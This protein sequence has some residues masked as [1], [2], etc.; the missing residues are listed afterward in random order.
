MFVFSSVDVETTSVCLV[1]NTVSYLTSEDETRTL[2][3]VV[4]YV[5][6]HGSELF[7]VHEIEVNLFICGDVYTD[8]SFDEIEQTFVLKLEIL[9]PIPFLGLFIVN[10]LEK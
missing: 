7:V 8:V 6:K 1:G 10:S 5:F 2:H 3:V 9:C 4:H